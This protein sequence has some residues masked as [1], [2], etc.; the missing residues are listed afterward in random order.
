MYDD[1]I[2]LY[3]NCS[4]LNSCY[5]SGYI[6]E[7]Y[8]KLLINNVIASG[9]S[10][11]YTIAFKYGHNISIINKGSD[12]ELIIAFLFDT[13]ARRSALDILS[14]MVVDILQFQEW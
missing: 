12:M 3:Q 8:C 6:I 11:L 5:I 9:C 7:C 14:F 1:A 4:W 10:T 13:L 2:I